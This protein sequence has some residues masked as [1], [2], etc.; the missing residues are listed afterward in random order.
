LEELM[1]MIRECNHDLILTS[2]GTSVGEE[3]L[4]YMAVEKLGKLLFHG[5]ALKPGKPTMMGIVE[6]RPLIGLPGYPSSALVVFYVLVAPLLRKM[7]GLP[8]FKPTTVK[9]KLASRVYSAKGRLE[10]VPVAMRDG[11]AR[12]IT[13]GSGAITTLAEAMGYVLVEENVEILE[14]G[15]EVDVVLFH[16]YA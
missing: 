7:A 11:R 2:G 9:A 12:P 14:E 5:V 15:S 1:G 6:R 13:K 16:D 10:Y 8:P 3:D 4:A